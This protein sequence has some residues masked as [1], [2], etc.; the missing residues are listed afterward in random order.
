[1]ILIGLP[2]IA[3][4]AEDFKIDQEK[5]SEYLPYTLEIKYDKDWGVKCFKMRR[6]GQVLKPAFPP[7]SIGTYIIGYNK[8][9]NEDN[10]AVFSMYEHGIYG[11]EEDDPID[12]I[13]TDWQMHF[14]L[15]WD[16]IAAVG[17][18]YRNDSVY[19]F[20]FAPEHDEIAPV[21]RF[22]S[23]AKDTARDHK[24][25]P[26]VNVPLIEDYD[27][28]GIPEVFIYNNT[29]REG[30]T[31]ELFCVQLTDFQTEWTVPVASLIFGKGIFSCRDSINPA[32]IF[33]TYNVAQGEEDNIFNDRC[34][35]FAKI[36]SNGNTEFAYISCVSHGATKLARGE[37]DSIFY[38][39][40]EI[41]LDSNFVFDSTWSADSS[42]YLS[43]V[44]RSGQI[45]KSVEIDGIAKKMWV[46]DYS[47]IHETAVYIN[48]NEERIVVY[49]TALTQIAAASSGHLSDFMGKIKI[50]HQDEEVFLFH[51]SI[52]SKDWDLLAYVPMG[53]SIM[54]LAY[55]SS[56]NVIKLLASGYNEA[57]I[58]NI[59]KKPLLELARIFYVNNQKYVL[60]LI[61][62]LVVGLVL[63]NYYRLRT[64]G[65]LKTIERQHKELQEA[66]DIIARQKAKEASAESYRV[67][68][69]QFRHEINN[70]L[71]V[72]RDYVNNV[73]DDSSDNGHKSQMRAKI[74]LLRNVLENLTDRIP[75]LSPDMKSKIMQVSD[76]LEKLNVKLLS[77]LNDIVLKGVET[78]LNLA[79]RLRKYE[80]IDQ[81]NTYH[82]IN[83]KNI[84]EHVFE[85]KSSPLACEK[86]SFQINADIGINL[87]GSEELFIIMFR[88]LLNN[89]IDALK[90]EKSTNRTISVS[91][92]TT[93]DKIIS[94]QWEDNGIG[95][96]ADDH[97]KI[98]QPFYTTKPTS[99][100]GLGLPMVQKIVEKYGG[101]IR[102]D[103]K[104]DNYTKFTID[105]P[106][107]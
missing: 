13:V 22:L 94:I 87:R 101:K 2:S 88:N 65:N 73:V 99:G 69:G 63:V 74:E 79:E 55:D 95:I 1:M 37:S 103:S 36:N 75:D 70:S 7:D 32:V 83:L 50:K 72:V 77:G 34:G 6:V 102:V 66:T 3:F 57:T 44:N 28:D 35:S 64:R 81:D 48:V 59:N 54:P 10:P 58:I 26:E 106:P 82:D 9:L 92:N 71:G 30:G 105:F 107:S 12:L 93:G 41:A 42:S 62:G 27:Y 98:F 67:A 14:N 16:C 46:T 53:H 100:S 17:A 85:E 97:E 8:Y 33:A 23:T 15:E 25:R 104:I 39:L 47:D 68:S 19:L 56:G 51:N 96:P 84:I 11:G 43:K 40:H 52:Y 91:A 61:S 5:P 20:K 78:G 89:S 86:I 76:D 45:L 38:L 29:V 21:Y 4:S 60:M 90:A 80:R 49:D 18:G 31:R 24:W